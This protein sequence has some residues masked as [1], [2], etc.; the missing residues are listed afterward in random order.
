MDTEH[1]VAAN[2]G[3]GKIPARADSAVLKQNN[4]REKKKN[5]ARV[6]SGP[7]L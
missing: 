6:A 7:R 1:G 3:W 2:A 4:F 5:F